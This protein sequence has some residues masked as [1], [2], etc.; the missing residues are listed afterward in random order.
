MYEIFQDRTEWESYNLMSSRKP[1][2]DMLSFFKKI[3]VL[4]VL[5]CILRLERILN[6]CNDS[7]VR[8]DC[9]TH[10]TKIDRYLSIS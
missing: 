7:T 8:L 6:C 2:E 4:Q 10:Y 5:L 1:N 9:D 3:H